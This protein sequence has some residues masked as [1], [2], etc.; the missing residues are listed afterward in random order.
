M[1]PSIEIIFGNH[2]YGLPY[3][4]GSRIEHHASEWAVFNVLIVICHMNSPLAR[5]IRLEG[6]I[7][8]SIILAD[9]T[10]KRSIGWRIRR[11]FQQFWSSR[12]MGINL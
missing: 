8:G 7:E 11:H 12:M 1:E 6:S 3:I 10:S 4:D 9:W 5:L 2:Y